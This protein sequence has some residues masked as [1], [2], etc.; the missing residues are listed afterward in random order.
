MNINFAL[1]KSLIQSAC[2]RPKMCHSVCIFYELCEYLSK[3]ASL[4]ESQISD[5]KVA[6]YRPLQ[7]NEKK[8]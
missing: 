3:E 8:P 2:F 5:W 6:F 7:K 1:H 4:P